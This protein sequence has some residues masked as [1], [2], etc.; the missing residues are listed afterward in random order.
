M[1]KISI[2]LIFTTAFLAAYADP[3]NF[4]DN[5]VRLET[6]HNVNMILTTAIYCIVGMIFIKWMLDHRLKN[7]L[8]EKGA[9]EHIVAQL[10]QPAP[11][12]SKNTTVKW[13]ALLMG[14]GTGLIL[15]Y[16][17]QPLGMHSLAI[18][19]FSL[20]AGILGYYFYLDRKKKD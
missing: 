16:N 5:Y 6:I 13:F 12:D 18:M 7:K 14:L 15:V 3:Q 10:L 8:I 1:K 19:C 9:P 11:N 2:T 4:T 17:F 20:A